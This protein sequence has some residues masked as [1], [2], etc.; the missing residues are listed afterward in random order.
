[1]AKTVKPKWST[2]WLEGFKS[3]NNI[4][5]RKQHGK[6][7]SVNIEGAEDRIIKLQAI[8]A[9]YP[10]NNIYNIDETGLF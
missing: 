4:H 3:H 9:P 2:G 1:M 5:K 7:A 10:P 6:A 8:V